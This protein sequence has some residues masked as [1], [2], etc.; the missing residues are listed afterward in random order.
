MA[1]LGRLRGRGRDGDYPQV[2]L[3]RLGGGEGQQ[4]LALF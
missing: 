2:A 4:A 3:R 1:N